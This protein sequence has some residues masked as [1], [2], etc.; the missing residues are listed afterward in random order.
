MP[1]HGPTLFVQVSSKSELLPNRAE[2]PV[3]TVLAGVACG[4]VV[5]G[6]MLA[7]GHT[8][9]LAGLQR[10]WTC[11]AWRRQR[12]TAVR[13]AGG[14]GVHGNSK[15]GAPTDGEEPSF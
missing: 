9:Q 14:N 15:D 1:I 13:A 6:T 3:R 5:T 12:H 7:L 2:L 4:L 8:Q 10:T 11:A